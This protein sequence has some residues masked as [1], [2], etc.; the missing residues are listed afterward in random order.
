MIQICLILAIV[1]ADQISKYAVREAM[2]VGQ[3]IELIP[4]LLALTYFRNDG[5]A[6]SS[7]RG[8]RELLIAFSA[9]AVVCALIFLFRKNREKN[10]LLEA[11]VILICGGG[12]G[13]LI[14]RVFF[15]TVTDMISVSFFPPIFNVADIAVVCGCGL[16]ILYVIASGRQE[17]LAAR[18]PQDEGRTDE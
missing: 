5:A 15:G 12:I 11:S 1:L 6:F 9:V 10:R 17:R 18:K 7:F 16:M 8:Q 2:T 14:D 3:S 13:N 4:K